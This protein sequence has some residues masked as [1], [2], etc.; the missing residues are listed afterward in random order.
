MDGMISFYT[1]NVKGLG[2]VEK[3]VEMNVLC[4]FDQDRQ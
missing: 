3:L 4:I 1:C 2:K